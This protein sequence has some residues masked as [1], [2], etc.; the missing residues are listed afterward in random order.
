MKRITAIALA[1]LLTVSTFTTSLFVFSEDAS[2]PDDAFDGGY[3]EFHGSDGSVTRVF[4]NGSVSTT[5]ADGSKS[6]VDYAGNQ[7]EQAS[8]GT[9]SVRA[10]D[11]TVATEYPDGTQSMTEPD[12]KTTTIRPDGSISESYGIG[13]TNDYDAEGNLVGVGIT[14]SEDRLGVDADGNV[15]N[16]ELKGPNGESLSVTDNGFSLTN[17]EGTT[18]DHTDTGAEKNTSIKWK[19]GTEY[20]SATSVSYNNGVRTETTDGSMRFADGSSWATNQSTDYDAD[21][22]PVYS[23]NNVS[24]WTSAD[25]STFWQDHNSGASEYRDTSGVTMVTD[26]YGNLT[27]YNDGRNI[28]NATYDENGDLSSS[29]VTYADGAVLVRNADGTASFTTPDGSFYYSDGQGNVT[30]NGVP[31]KQNGIFVDQPG[32]GGDADQYGDGYSEGYSDGTEDGYGDGYGEG[33]EDGYSGGYTDDPD[34]ANPFGGGEITVTDYAPPSEITGV[35]AIED[36]YTDEIPYWLNGAWSGASYGHEGEFTGFHRES[37]RY[38]ILNNHTLLE[39]EYYYPDP[40]HPEFPWGLD[41]AYERE[42]LYYPETQTILIYQTETGAI[43][44]AIYGQIT[45]RTNLRSKRIV[46]VPEKDYL[47]GHPAIRTTLEPR[48]MTGKETDG[49]TGTLRFNRGDS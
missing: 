43:V 13:V 2:T 10:T 4:D 32:D 18:F 14:G 48:E 39:E 12:G 41:Y 23:A 42:Y 22:N 37:V 27:E 16:G 36:G 5:Y 3:A 35:V 30:L 25:G 1:L 49:N 31:V 15:M 34:S 8:D 11:G 17:A 29:Y 45:E 26:K 24:Q 6:G 44:G 7:Y 19:N 47:T 40:D 28:V 21:G 38:T 9:Y 33:T 46:R 20:S